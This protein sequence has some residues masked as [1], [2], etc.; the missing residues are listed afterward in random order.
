MLQFSG[1]LNRNRDFRAERESCC[2]RQVNR[3]YLPGA[4]TDARA[5]GIDSAGTGTTRVDAELE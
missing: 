5:A 1:R 2:K 3:T 4:F